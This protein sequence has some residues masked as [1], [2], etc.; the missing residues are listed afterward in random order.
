MDDHPYLID[1]CFTFKTPDLETAQGIRM[2][3]SQLTLTL[4]L[5]LRTG[6]IQQQSLPYQTLLT[7]LQWTQPR[8]QM[9]Q[10]DLQLTRVFHLAA[11]FRKLRVHTEVSLLSHHFALP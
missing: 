6:R 7:V 3:H 11:K 4:T 8:M 10:A 5:Q 1:G 2:G 9:H